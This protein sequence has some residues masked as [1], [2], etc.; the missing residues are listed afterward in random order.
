MQKGRDF[1]KRVEKVLD[2]I[3]S[4]GGH[5]HKNNAFRTIEGDFIK[6]EPFD[7]EAFIPGYHCV[8]D[9]KKSATD[10]WHMQKKDLIQANNLKKCKNAGLNAYFLI[11]FENNDVKEIDI[12]KVVDVLERGSKSIP[13]KL[14]TEWQLL[15]ILEERS[16]AK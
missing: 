14:G 12:D 16:K 15:K 4:I 7:Y 3:D 10:V 11:C 2:Y 9:A 6:G 5:A 8:F 1:E 13:K